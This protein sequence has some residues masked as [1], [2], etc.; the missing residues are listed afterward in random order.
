MQLTYRGIQYDYN[1]PKVEISTIDNPE[2]DWRFHNQKTSGVLLPTVNLTWRGVKY[3]NLPTG[4]D[5]LKEKSR[6]LML[7]HQRKQLDRV[8]KMHI[9]SA[10]EIGLMQT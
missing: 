5:S 1:P 2:L 9:R 7:R 6:Y 3:N 4:M 8:A 10:N